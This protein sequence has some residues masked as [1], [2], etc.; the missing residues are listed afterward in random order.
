M[1]REPQDKTKERILVPSGI[2]RITDFCSF[3]IENPDHVS[4][5]FEESALPSPYPILVSHKNNETKL[6]HKFPGRHITTFDKLKEEV[7]DTSI[8]LMGMT[9]KAKKMLQ[10]VTSYGSILSLTRDMESWCNQAFKGGVNEL[11]LPITFEPGRNNRT[12]FVNLKVDYLRYNQENIRRIIEQ[13][14]SK[15]APQYMFKWND[16]EVLGNYK[17]MY[18]IGINNP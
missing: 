15:E 16:T 4:E 5:F 8:D 2:Q 12:L 3:N 13:E 9:P 10:T 14:P 11:A 7:Y 17:R 1:D 18:V 6:H